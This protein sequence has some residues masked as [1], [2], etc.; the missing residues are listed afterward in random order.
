[1]QKKGMRPASVR[2]GFKLVKAQ[3]YRGTH[4]K[5]AG[6]LTNPAKLSPLRADFRS[7]CRRSALI[8]KQ[9]RSPSKPASSDRRRS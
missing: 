1:L 9:F 5:G 8:A 3:S 2:F 4:T 6:W 7:T